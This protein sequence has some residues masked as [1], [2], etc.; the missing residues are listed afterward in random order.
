VLSAVLVC[1]VASAAELFRVA[2]YNLD[3]YLEA[4]TGARPV[5]SS[6]GKAKIREGLRA[7]QADVVA[8]EE[9]GSAHALLE[10]R[11]SLQQEGWDYPY[12]EH[13]TGFDTNIHVA[14]LSRFPITAR[15]PHTN[16]SFLLFG[17]R[18]RVSRGFAEVD[19]QVNPHYAFTLIAAHL[20][21]RRPVPEADETELR[22]QEAMRL[23]EWID[24]RLMTDP[25]ANLIVLGDL[26]D[27]K[28]AKSTRAVMGRGKRG[29]IDTRPAERNGDNQPNPNPRYD[30][31]NITWTHYYGKE[32]SYSR[33]DYILLSQGMA[34]E[35]SKQDTY[36]LALP[37]WGIASDHRP[38]V[39]GFWA[40][41]K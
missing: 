38:I 10:L 37:N 26:N 31:R 6:E 39:A 20:K 18:F 27:V 21:S 41:D 12:W 36:V 19:I 3:N 25:N 22:E 9:M 17:R 34:R 28:D 5:K 30:P 8:L 2:T 24:V 33:I 7:L 4:P 13:V 29:L 16:D 40:E 1:S 11:Q 32:D 14:V 35:W 15:R 23:R